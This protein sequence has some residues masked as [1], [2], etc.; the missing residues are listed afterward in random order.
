[1][2]INRKSVLHN[3]LAIGG[4]VL[5]SLVPVAVYAQ[6]AAHGDNG[7]RFAT[8][9]VVENNASAKS[10]Q[11]PTAV[12]P[13]HQYPLEDMAFISSNKVVF[14]SLGLIIHNRLAQNISVAIHDSKGRRVLIKQYGAESPVINI[15]TSGLEAGAY[16][17][18]VMIGDSLFTR[19]FFVTHR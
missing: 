12:K 2:D 5:W 8:Q 14:N 13:T 16:I 10:G 15:K 19:P 17:Y 9:T 11:Q 4:I 1:M 7:I 18:S 6:V 3:A